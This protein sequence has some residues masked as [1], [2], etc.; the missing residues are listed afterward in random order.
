MTLQEFIDRDFAGNISAFA[1]S[2]GITRSTA[3]RLIVG[4]S[5]PQIKLRDRLKRKGVHF[6]KI[7]KGKQC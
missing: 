2:Y 4:G 6:E 7:S 3:Y 5:Y 1:R